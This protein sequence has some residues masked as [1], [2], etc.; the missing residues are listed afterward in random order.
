MEILSVSESTIRKLVRDKELAAPKKVG[1]RSAR[2]FR[3]DVEQYLA[4]LKASDP[5]PDFVSAK[6]RH[7]APR[8]NREEEEG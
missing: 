1:Q 3:E 4:V 5:D 2:W 7:G 6:A 8:D